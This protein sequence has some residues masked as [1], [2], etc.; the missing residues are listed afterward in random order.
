MTLGALLLLTPALTGC[1]RTP[2]AGAVRADTLSTAEAAPLP[3]RPATRTDT[4]VVGGTPEPV[5]VTLRRVGGRL[6]LYAPGEMLFETASSPEGT[7]ATLQSPDGAVSMRVFV[8]DAGTYGTF[9]ALDS[10]ITAP[11]GLLASNAARVERTERTPEGGGDVRV[12]HYV[13]GGE[14]DR[15][16]S[17]IRVGAHGA[18]PFYIATFRPAGYAGGWEPRFDAIVRSIRWETPPAAGAAATPEPSE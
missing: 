5:A 8:A 14:G 16:Q 3:E 9:A 18:V 10:F 15:L 2:D 12:T 4:V 1:K 7:A 17:T 6:S 13:V 11:D